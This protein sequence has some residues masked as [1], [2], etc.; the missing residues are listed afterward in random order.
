M[1][2]EIKENSFIVDNFDFIKTAFLMMIAFYFG[3]KSLELIGYKSKHVYRA[4]D[5]G[6][7]Q[8]QMMR[9]P[10]PAPPDQDVTV[11]KNVLKNHGTVPQKPEP[12]VNKN[13]FDNP[14]AVQ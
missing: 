8:R 5:S 12:T 11:V 2:S 1:P 10:A 13:D 7:E 4:G 6:S 3:H 14:D 9:T